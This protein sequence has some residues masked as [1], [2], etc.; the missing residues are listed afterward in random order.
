MDEDD[1]LTNDELDFSDDPDLS[2]IENDEDL[3][4]DAVVE[5]T[6]LEEMTDDSVRVYLREIGRI[7]LLTQD[8]E[9]DLAAKIVANDEPLAEVEASL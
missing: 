2:D 5:P 9:N 6:D 3:A 7:P 4:D 8:E 1:T